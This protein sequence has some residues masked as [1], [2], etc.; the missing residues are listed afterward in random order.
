MSIGHA[1][2]GTDGASLGFDHHFDGEEET[3]RPGEAVSAAN[4]DRFARS[5]GSRAI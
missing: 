2:V 3:A 4:A 5:V 1:F